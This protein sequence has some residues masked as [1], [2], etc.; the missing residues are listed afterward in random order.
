M[1]SNDNANLSNEDVSNEAQIKK[2]KEFIEP[3]A[4][5]NSVAEI[6]LLEKPKKQIDL[7]ENPIVSLHIFNRLL[8]LE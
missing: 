8:F 1:T 4:I 5:E 7:I 6:A 3:E 2:E